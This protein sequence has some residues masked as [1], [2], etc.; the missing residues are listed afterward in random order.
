MKRPK[1]TRQVV[2]QSVRSHVPLPKFLGR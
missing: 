1:A 2:A